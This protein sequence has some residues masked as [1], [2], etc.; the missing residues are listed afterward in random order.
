MAVGARSEGAPSHAALLRLFFFR[1]EDGRECMCVCAGPALTDGLVEDGWGPDIKK[2]A[3]IH[4]STNMCELPIFFF[5]IP[6]PNQTRK[7]CRGQ[8]LVPS[9]G[10]GRTVRS[11]FARHVTIACRALQLSLPTTPCNC[12]PPPHTHPQ[13]RRHLNR[14]GSEGAGT[15]MGPLPADMAAAFQAAVATHLAVRTARCVHHRV[16][17]GSAD[18]K[19]TCSCSVSGL[20]APTQHHAHHW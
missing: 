5:S 10:A 15:S 7:V 14:Q 6:L 4:K 13:V 1:A 2:C 17:P 19:A 8:G 11:H 3:L 12:P 16:A 20:D 18:V 9:N